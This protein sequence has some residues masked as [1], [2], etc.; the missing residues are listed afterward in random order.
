MLEREVAASGIGDEGGRES[1]ERIRGNE[2]EERE[3]Q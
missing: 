1:K 3:R 2:K